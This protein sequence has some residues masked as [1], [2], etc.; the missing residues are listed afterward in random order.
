MTE[1]LTGY[2]T[3][4]RNFATV[5]ANAQVVVPYMDGFY[6]NIAAARARF[7]HL[8]VIEHV[9]SLT[10]RAGDA[11]GVDWEPGN[12]CPDPFGWYKQQ[13]AL[14][15]WRPLYYADISDMNAHI[16]P[17]L[18]AGG[19]KPEID[20]AQRPVRILTAHPTQR[21][22]ICG[23]HTCGQLEF[24]A[25]GT[26]W[27]WS[28]LAHSPLDRDVS[29]FRADAI[30]GKKVAPADPYGVFYDQSFVV[31][32]PRNGKKYKSNER[33]AAKNFDNVMK[34]PLRNMSQ[35]VNA[36]YR[37]VAHRKYVWDRAHE[38]LDHGKASWGKDRR[39]SRWHAFNNRT[40][41]L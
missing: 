34:H 11:D 40:Q 25:D 9:I 20:F 12:T 17:S 22:H 14:G 23:P 5:P 28:S 33:D 6:N 15:R 38:D 31:T 24:D 7:G 3:A 27:W 10:C 39:G 37:C 16:I 36:I 2:D 32:D 18:R 41:G 35:T 4:A 29:L 13:H 19:L 8:F 21:Q 26:Q 30:G 1:Y